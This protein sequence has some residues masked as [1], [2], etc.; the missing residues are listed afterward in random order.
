VPVIGGVP[1]GL[2]GGGGKGAVQSM[3]PPAPIVQAFCAAAG[4]ARKV[5]A[6][7]KRGRKVVEESS[8]ERLGIPITPGCPPHIGVF[9]P[10]F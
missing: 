4:K 8:F 5:T 10:L 1:G 2:P 7:T 6:P 3:I 9:R